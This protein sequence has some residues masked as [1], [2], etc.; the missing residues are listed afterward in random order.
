MNMS[1]HTQIIAE[2]GVNHNGSLDLAIQLVDAA[3]S[4][5]ADVVK[6]QTFRADKLVSRTAPK[7]EYQKHNT[8]GGETQHEMIR[9]LELDE[10]A[11]L[12][13]HRHC[14]SKGITFMST[15]FDLE[16]LDMLVAGFDLPFIKLASG[17]ITNAPFLLAAA[18]TG[19]PIILST[20]MSDLGEVE[21]A[22]AVLAFG[23]SSPDAAPSLAGFKA[24]Y[25]SEV[26]Q[27]RL[28]EKVT[29]LHCTTEYPAPFDEVNLRAMATLRQAFSLPVGYSDHTQGIAIPIAAAALGATVIEKHFT[30]D[31]TLPGPDH[32]ASLE[33]SEL[34]DMVRAIRQVERSMG[35]APKSPSTSELKNRA[36]A[37]KSLV[38]ACE[39]L[40]GEVFSIKNLT[41]KRPGDGISPL[42][43]WDWLGKRALRPY[44]Q[45]ESIEP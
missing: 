10:A 41:V 28:Q 12:R 15:P 23:Y 18:R 25:Y 44:L 14:Q 1:I 27:S 5:G 21:N 32:Q 19:R 24:A 11:H 39:I 30:L 2:A 26:G 43:Y 45:D 33:P 38:A 16:S 22:L 9:R 6:F 35:R 37:R 13:L 7:A 8:G 42:Y 36:V 20:G 29:L 4:A 3:V 34:A 17:E 31:R 40:Q